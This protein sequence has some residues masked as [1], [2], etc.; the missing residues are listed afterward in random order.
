MDDGIGG[1]TTA[2]LYVKVVT[3][4]RATPFVTGDEKYKIKIDSTRESTRERE[5]LSLDR[6]NDG[7]VVQQENGPKRGSQG[8]LIRSQSR[9]RFKEI[10]LDNKWRLCS[11]VR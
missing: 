5:T 10:P 4:I 1:Q 7:E 6:T 3:S 2:V 11:D 9:F 8:K